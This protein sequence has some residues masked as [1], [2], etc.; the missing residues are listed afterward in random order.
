MV[1][2]CN[3]L[4]KPIVLLGGKADVEKAKT[5][6]K[7]SRANILNLTGKLSI[8]QSASVVKKADWVITPDTGLMH[9]AAAFNRRIIS[10]WGN[11]VPEFGM[12]PYKT[13]PASQLFQVKNL[14]CRPCSKIGFEKCPKKHFNCMMRQ[15]IDAMAKL[16]E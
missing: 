5:I 13:N 16:G 11:T 10:Y 9:I 7:L 6:E 1:Q 8:N 3:A 14:T 4:I 12:T 2:L 15:D